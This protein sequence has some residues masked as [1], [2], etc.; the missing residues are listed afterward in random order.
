MLGNGAWVLRFLPI[1][2]FFHFA[3][4]AHGIFY[5][6]GTSRRCFSPSPSWLCPSLVPLQ[7][8]S[9][10]SSRLLGSHYPLIVVFGGVVPLREWS[11]RAVS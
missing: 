2:R 1:G 10:S 6:D 3:G 7:L 9:K 11:L 4:V 8:L 5:L